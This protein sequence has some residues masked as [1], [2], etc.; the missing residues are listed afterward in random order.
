MPI[1]QAGKACQRKSTPKPD[2]PEVPN[3]K[4]QIPESL[5][6]EQGFESLGKNPLLN[7]VGFS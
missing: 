7:K 3:P 2:K 1:S 6:K 5:P 4:C